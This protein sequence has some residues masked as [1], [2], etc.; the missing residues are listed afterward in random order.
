MAEFLKYFGGRHRAN[1]SGRFC[2]FIPAIFFFQIPEYAADTTKAQRLLHVPFQMKQISMI[3][4]HYFGSRTLV[5]VEPRENT[6]EGMLVVISRP[7][8]NDERG[9]ME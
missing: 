5:V 1:N 4:G 8:C 2:F 7:E 6:I 3:W 9:L